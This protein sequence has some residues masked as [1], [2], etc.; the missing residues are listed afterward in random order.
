MDSMFRECSVLTSLDLSSFNA[1]NVTTMESM[2]CG[3]T[4]L[5][6]L[7]LS[8][9]NAANVEN[10]NDMFY[11]CS[12]LTTAPALPASTL[13]EYC[14]SNMFDNCTALEYAPLLPALSTETRSYFMMFDGCSKLKQV[15]LNLLSGFDYTMLEHTNTTGT[16]I[17]S[18]EL[19]ALLSKNDYKSVPSGWTVKLVRRGNVDGN[20]GISVSDLT[21]LIDRLH[22]GTAASLDAKAADMDLNGVINT[23]DVSPLAKKVLNL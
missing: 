14:Y 19:D 6:A 8:N 7:D 11:G 9:F 12:S 17:V 5:T 4:A 15:E 18:E 13:A 20:G 3:S 1:T 10:L 22:K 2:F 23:N 16:L 21:T